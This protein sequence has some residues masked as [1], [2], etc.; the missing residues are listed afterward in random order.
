MPN[1]E[2]LDPNF[3][4]KQE[5]DQKGITFHNIEE[6]PFKIYGVTKQATEA[7]PNGQYCRMDH[8]VSKEVSYNVTWLNY[9]TAGG[10]VR[11]KTNSP[12]VTILFKQSGIPNYSH[13]C[14]VGSS[15][16]DLY[17]E[18]DDG[19]SVYRG[20]F[21]PPFDKKDGYV[22]SLNIG[23]GEMKNVCI[24]FPL[25]SN[26]I[27]LQIGLKNDAELIAPR[28]YTIEKPIIYYGSSITQG[29]CASRPGNSYQGFISRHFDCDYLNLG[30]AGSAKGEPAASEYIKNLDMSVFVYDY[31]YNAPDLEH[32]KATHETFFK[33]IRDA[34][35]ELPIIIMSRPYFLDD[36]ETVSRREIIEA[37]YNNAIKSGD[38][39]VYFL[40]GKQLM[41]LCGNDG[42][43]DGCH[44]NDLG[45]FS[46]AQALIKV[47]EKIFK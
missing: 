1:L 21:V 33:V 24:N 28:P 25:Y 39:N 43:V 4:V 7:E 26:V 44:P 47:L 3:K 12:T 22:S 10:R 45:F 27:D 20:S 30:Y 9:N 19:T 14:R 37:T 2:E 46:M 35:P 18:E 34:H 32:L 17:L 5:Y 8:K 23:N 41:A 42:N 40:N 36:P 16:F 6:E 38:K 31:D 15:G 13:M 11:F 29:G